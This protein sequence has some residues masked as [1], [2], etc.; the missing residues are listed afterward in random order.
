MKKLVSLV[1][2]VIM[3]LCAVPALA[4]EVNWADIEAQAADTVARGEFVA[5]DEIA[6]Q[7]WIPEGLYAVELAEEDLEEGYIAYFMSEDEANAVAVVYVDVDGMT[8]EEYKALL[9]ENGATE[10]EDVIVNGI[11]AITYVLEED[12]T[13][14]ISF[15]TE[16]GY[17][18]EISGA[19]KSDEGFAAVLSFIMASIQETALE[20]TAAEAE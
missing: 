2:A 14:C 16:A 19:P 6:V 13:A 5:L 12:D 1:L 7:M 8:L 3:L 11:P 17:I 9:P 18:L 15:A 20:A 10:I 4:T